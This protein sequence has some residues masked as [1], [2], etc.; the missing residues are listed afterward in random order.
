MVTRPRLVQ[1]LP[2]R[3]LLCA[4]TF[5]LAA[6]GT[7]RVVPAAAHPLHT[8]ITDVVTDGR[9][10]RASIR[11]FGDDFNAAIA[12]REPRAQSSPPAFERA[13]F[14]Y[15]ARTFVLRRDR[16]GTV[17]LQWC[18][19]RRENDLLLLCVHASLPPGTG[20]WSLSSTLLHEMFDDQV[21]VVRIMRGTTRQ[22]MLFVRGDGAKTIR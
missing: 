10:V 5:A 20:Q 6:L 2:V 3:R 21:N 1:V 8:T 14:A 18:G 13:A 17:P 11:I 9:S 7:C 19:L 22:H 4:A 12:R 15:I 16:G